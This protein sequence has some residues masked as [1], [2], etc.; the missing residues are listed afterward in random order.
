MKASEVV[1]VEDALR[2]V[3]GCLN[4]LENG[5]SDR[6]ETEMQIINL[7]ARVADLQKKECE[8]RLAS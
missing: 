7:C 5:I 4:D 1:T 2:F 6:N 8:K 3:Q